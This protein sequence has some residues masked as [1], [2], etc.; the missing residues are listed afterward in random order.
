MAL[1]IA[2]PTAAQTPANAAPEAETPLREAPRISAVEMRSELPSAR[3]QHLRDLLDFGPGDR[4][5]EGTVRRSLR[6]LLASGEV[7]EVAIY[8]RPDPAR[9]G[10]VVAV[11]ALWPHLIVSEVVL[12]GEPKLPE[13][14]LR[15]R[16]GQRA[17]DPLMEGR[18]LQGLYRIEEQ[19]REAGYLEAQA[20]LQVRP[21]DGPQ[22]VVV[23]YGIE[24]GPR[25]LV[26][27]VQWVGDLGPF[28]T[29]ELEE[30][31]RAGPGEPYD[32]RRLEEDPRRL[33]RYLVQQG[34]RQVRV[35][36]PR[37][38][39]RDGAVDLAYNVDL[40]RPVA[41]VVRGAEQE[42]LERKG[43]LP[44]LDEDGYDQALLIRTR[45]R[46]RN[47]YQEKGHYRV[48][49]EAYEEARE[50]SGEASEETAVEDQPLTVVVE[51]E[52]GP[53]M[54]L[55]ELELEGNRSFADARLSALMAT[56]P[57]RRLLPGSGY[58]VDDVLAEDLDNL[59]S[60]YAL[61]GFWQ[62]EVGE[63]TISQELAP[64]TD[65][66]TL[67]VTV[68]IEEGPRRLVASFQ[69]SGVEHLPESA[70]PPAPP[71]EEG[72]PYH[73]LRVEEA[74]EQL[75]L[76]YQGAGFEWVQITPRLDWLDETLVDVTLE[77]LE[78]PR[79]LLD[80]LVLR[81]NQKTDDDILR[82][83]IDLES[84]SPVSRQQLL[85]VQ[86]DLSRLGVFSRVDVR[87]LPG[88]VGGRDRD[89]VVR[90]E[91][92]TAQR[93][94]YG[95]GY[96]SD[97]GVRGLLGYSHRN[98]FGRALALQ[99]DTRLSERDQLYRVSL[100]QPYL[101]RWDIPVTYSLFSFLEDRQSFDQDSRGL[102]IEAYRLLPRR[103]WG[104]V[105]DLR[106]IDLENVEGSLDRI[107]RQDREIEITSLIPSLLLD[108][109]DDPFDP[110]E[111]W[112]T[113]LQLQYAFPA[114]ST[115]AHFLKLFVQQSHYLPLG[116]AGVVAA[117]LRMGAIEPVGDELGPVPLS[118]DQVDNPVPI[119]E[120]FFLGG[121]T[122]H[123]SFDR[124]LLGITGVTRIA[125]PTGDGGVEL[126]PVGGNGLLLANLEYRFPILGPLGGTVFADV[127]NV[128]RDWRDVDPEQLR[129]GVG[130]G[131]R[132]SSPIGP[133]RLEVGFNFD[134]E[135]GEDRT[136]VHLT[137]GN[138]F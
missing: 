94:S 39:L 110:T 107:E 40:G 134:Q 17:G 9:D 109:R 26:G 120:R 88:E 116:R 61:E 51:I 19:H 121:R 96:D 75:R 97:D 135:P 79:M 31:L 112:S 13:E 108:H 4:L 111:G 21:G 82:R 67:R 63:P 22:R 53:V 65:K 66:G 48:E 77:V 28:S 7:A 123:R 124:D 98:L 138:P 95:L 103:R 38:D 129:Y 69:R 25:T 24:P 90:V 30:Q 78:G 5:T 106:Y 76:A 42:K 58:L 101:L 83:F 8:R 33:R 133:V 115:D 113:T 119:G 59:R 131:L 72:G 89:V 87:L 64:G 32:S 118:E 44:F 14:R 91:E 100:Q 37:T 128:W 45:D 80:R 34:Y 136:E 49:V 47:H 102:R 43:L 11:V 85:E 57:R 1:G 56:Q 130:V 74:V 12:E 73:P 62:A 122:T 127:G 46:L 81:G 104:L 126:L 52:P 84:G 105:A 71:L 16:L 86:R 114:F 55:E 54:A 92:G 29:V 132:Y 41:V 18:V 68:P 35:E 50:A 2:A 70:L 3:V 10:Q 117:S 6:E 125:D 60:F 20:R 15:S 137:F 36:A 99:M 93:V 27:K 23:V